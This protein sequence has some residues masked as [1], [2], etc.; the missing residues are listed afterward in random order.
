LSR[1][2]DVV[3][4]PVP[5]KVVHVDVDLSHLAREAVLKS[6]YSNN[7]GKMTSI[8]IR[9]VNAHKARTGKVVSAVSLRANETFLQSSYP[10]QGI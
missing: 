10:R 8:M 2:T 5:S 6:A 9:A 1:D 7:F 3:L 4:S